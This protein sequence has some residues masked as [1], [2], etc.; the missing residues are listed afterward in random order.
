VGIY[1]DDGSAA[2]AARDRL[3]AAGRS[4]LSAFVESRAAEAE[5]AVALAC[6]IATRTACAVHLR[7]LSTSGSI[8]I[9]RSAR[10]QGADVS[11]EVT[12]HHLA[13][14][15]PQARARGLKV[16][17]P[18]RSAVDRAAL[19]RAVVEGA[20]DIVASDHAPHAPAEK[21][22]SNV[23]DVP[24]GLPGVQTMLS[25]LLGVFGRAAAPLVARVCAQAPASRFGLSRKGAIEP[26][27]DADLVLV[28][29]DA[30]WRVDPAALYSHGAGSPFEG[31]RL[32]G[33]VRTTILRGQ[34]IYH[35][36]DFPSQPL[37]RWLRPSHQAAS[38]H[39]SEPVAQPGMNV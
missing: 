39:L 26:G 13:L 27:R 36:G 10:R 8:A 25:A 14:S 23:W 11:V 1:C 2:A 16:L 19:R 12:P 9:A 21:Q 31:D 17:P 30:S 32:P 5:T 34:V 18:L 38:G 3:I 28:D 35:D 7:Q 22:R 29:V 20:V 37:G 33:V 4:D 24:A 15:D 6:S